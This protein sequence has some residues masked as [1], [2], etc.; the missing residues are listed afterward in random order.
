MGD[1]SS[2]TS[3]TTA[4]A[5]TTMM[6]M[7]Q[8]N[9]ATTMMPV[10]EPMATVSFNVSVSMS[11]EDA[12]SNFNLTAY[13]MS[14]AA[15][16]EP[17]AQVTVV[18]VFKMKVEYSFAGA[19][20]EAAVKPQIA[21]VNSVSES[22]VSVVITAVPASRRLE[23]LRRLDS[24]GSSSATSTVAAEIATE[25]QNQLQALQTTMEE[26]LV[27]GG[28]TAVASNAT[29]DV[30]LV[31]TVVQSTIAAPPSAAAV[32]GFFPNVEVVVEVSEAYGVVWTNM[33][34][35][36]SSMSCNAGRQKRENA[37]SLGCSDAECGPTDED[38]CCE[39]TGLAGGNS[40]AETLS[41][42]L[43]SIFVVFVSSFF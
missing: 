19:V 9:S 6:P 17:N 24:H 5:T 14:L 16:Y 38:T 27:V 21:T 41:K 12:I 33:A 15:T 2:N 1:T 30:E 18:A 13:Q 34:C 26:P 3:V 31:T 7:N 40:N 8:T 42:P 39:S 37:A 35:S 25:N 29:V 4:A 11:A 43:A 20:T 10:P 22:Q 32:G 28:V 36:D 23:S